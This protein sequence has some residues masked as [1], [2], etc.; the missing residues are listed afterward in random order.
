[1]SICRPLSIASGLNSSLTHI[2]SR[3]HSPNIVMSHI[4]SQRSSLILQAESITNAEKNQPNQLTLFK[5]IHTTG[6]SVVS[7]R[8]EGFDMM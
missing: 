3:A 8:M 1:M 4:M 5:H 6:G 2:P 7:K